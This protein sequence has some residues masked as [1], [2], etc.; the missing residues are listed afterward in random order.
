MASSAFAQISKIVI[1]TATRPCV[2]SHY[3]FKR[4]ENNEELKLSILNGG[5]W[6]QGAFTMQNMLELSLSVIG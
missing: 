2:V 4:V 1:C 3:F 6:T 5:R